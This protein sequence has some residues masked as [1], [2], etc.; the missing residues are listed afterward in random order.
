MQKFI[1]KNP[2]LY[3]G[4]VELSILHPEN[5]CE[6]AQ[7]VKSSHEQL[8]RLLRGKKFR[9]EKRKRHGD[10]SVRNL[11]GDFAQA[12]RETTSEQFLWELAEEFGKPLKLGGMLIP[13]EVRLPEISDAVREKLIHLVGDQLHKG[14]NE[15]ECKLIAQ[16]VIHDLLLKHGERVVTKI[17]ER[18]H[19]YPNLVEIP[20]PQLGR[21]ITTIMERSMKL[22]GLPTQTA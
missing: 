9:T 2:E 15:D 13:N 6:L 1:L 17:K 10:E 8:R 22:L 4:D 18:C 3:M 14:K 20:Q 11:T 16:Q 5:L 7:Y 19:L 12:D 21:L